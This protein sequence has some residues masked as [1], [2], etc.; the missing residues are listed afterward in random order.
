MT[1]N[2]VFCV[3]LSTPFSNFFFLGETFDPRSV[4]CRILV[5][6]FW[7]FAYLLMALYT[8]NLAAQLTADK[9]VSNRPDSLDAFAAQTSFKYSVAAD[10]AAYQYLAN[11]RD[12]ELELKL[13]WRQRSAKTDVHGWSKVGLSD[14]NPASTWRYPIQERVTNM[15]AQ[16]QSWGMPNTTEQALQKIKQDDWTV[17]LDTPL[18]KYHVARDCNLQA[19][20]EAFAY[21]PYGIAL[22]KNSPMKK[23]IDLE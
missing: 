23:Q 7:F 19:V 8:A 14:V 5:I 11:L 1:L 12:A 15:L 13:F 20:G 17:V 10:S 18:I 21:R 3:P 2:K 4:S 22:R 9:L 16:I 6:G